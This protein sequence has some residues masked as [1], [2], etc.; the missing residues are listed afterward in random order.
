MVDSQR[1][2]GW[3]SIATFLG[4]ERTTVIRWANERGMPVHRVP[5]GRTGTVYA[6]RSE[7]DDWLAGDLDDPKPARQAEGKTKDQ[8]LVW[9]SARR[10]ALV[11]G[12]SV[13]FAIVMALT[14]TPVASWWFRAIPPAGHSMLVYLSGFRPLSTDL[15]LAMRERINAEITAAFNI[16]GV[17]GVSTA[18]KPETGTAPAYLLDGVI[19]RVGDSIRVITR[20]SNERSGVVLWSDSVDYPGD[21][22]SKVP[23]KI[24]VDASTV[25]RCGLSGAATYRKSLPD[26]FLSNYMQYCQQYWSYGGSKTLHFARLVVAAAPDFSWGWSAVGNGFVQ[27]ALVEHDSRRAAIIRAEGR[28]AEDRA[29]ALDHNNSEALAHKAYLVDPHDWIAQEAL[30]KRAIAAKPLDC[31]CEHYGYGLKLESV[32]RLKAAIEQYRAAIDMLALWPDSQLALARALEAT[33]RGDQAGP[34]FDAAIDLS[35]DA[36][37]DRSIAMS[38]GMETGDYAAAMTALRNPQLRI[39]KESRD[40]LFAGY[41]A[42]ASADTQVKTKARQMLLSLPKDQQGDSVATLLG[43]LG[44]NGEALQ[45]AGRKPWLFWRR[46]MHGVL[47]EPAF[48]AIA[49]ELGLISYWKISHTKP[50]VCLK[51]HGPPFCQMI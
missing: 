49:R 39:S 30:F 9:R 46:S 20:L 19:Y 41:G 26:S 1:L 31:G 40:A 38:E 37:L 28:Q 47:N 24:A 16:D 35:N 11:A 43:A 17:I 6:V 45:I 5:G 48:P 25:V 13:L 29:L 22:V 2:D 21:Q 14:V 51:D 36:N 15:P 33:G 12:L 10:P 34:Y 8:S 32:G 50:D 27:V 42:L 18:P 3:K 44:A 23:H 7:L 4:R